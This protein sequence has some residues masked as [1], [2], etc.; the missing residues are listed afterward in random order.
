M[1]YETLIN[2]PITVWVFFDK[3]IFPIAMNWRRRLIKFQKLIFTSSKKV[4]ETKILNLIC[5][6][7]SANFELEYDSSNYLWTL[8]K[9]MPI[10]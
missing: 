3:G 2:E 9:V 1:S 5:A 8:K 6:S 10:S 4:G 7:D